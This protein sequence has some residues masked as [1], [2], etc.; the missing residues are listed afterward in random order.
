MKIALIPIRFFLASVVT[1]LFIVSAQLP[2]GIAEAKNWKL[3]DR[4]ECPGTLDHKTLK[5]KRPYLCEPTRCFGCTDVYSKEDKC[6]RC[7][8]L[9]YSDCK[10][11][12]TLL[13]GESPGASSAN[14]PSSPSDETLPERYKP[15]T[16]L[17]VHHTQ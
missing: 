10:V 2:V 7:G 6:V 14:A 3:G 15:V 5:C 12:G 4:G 1:A 16:H 9:A 8:A 11:S 17:G 13:H